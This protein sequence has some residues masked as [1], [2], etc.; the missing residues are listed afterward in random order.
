MGAIL[1]NRYGHESGSRESQKFRGEPGRQEGREIAFR[2]GAG[3]AGK[4][5]A[6]NRAAKA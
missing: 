3:P 6:Q 5:L 1:D 4:A 2:G